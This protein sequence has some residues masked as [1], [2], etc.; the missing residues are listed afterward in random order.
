LQAKIGGCCEAEPLG[1]LRSDGRERG[2][3]GS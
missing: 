3:C 2:W 1:K